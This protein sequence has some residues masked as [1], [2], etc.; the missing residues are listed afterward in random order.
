MACHGS[1]HALLGLMSRVKPQKSLDKSEIV[2]VS[3]VK[4]PGVPTLTEAAPLALRAVTT[5]NL[6]PAAIRGNPR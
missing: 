6:P 2:T 4:T 1:W 5:T 3:R